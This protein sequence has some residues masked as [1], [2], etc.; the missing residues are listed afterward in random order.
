[1]KLEHLKDFIKC[2]NSDQNQGSNQQNRHKRKEIWSKEKN[3]DGQWR[4]Y[5]YEEIIA[6]DKTSLDIFWLKDKSLAD[7]D[8][9]PEPEDLATEIIENIEAGLNS[10]REVVGILN[11]NYYFKPIHRK[12]YEK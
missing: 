3:P 1:M 6:R 12:L 10:F 8:N 5:T 4:K 11:T 7:L 2:F 9:L